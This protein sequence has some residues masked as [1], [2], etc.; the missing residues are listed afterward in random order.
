MLS[1]APSNPPISAVG[2]DATTQ[3]DT[4]DPLTLN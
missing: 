3:H 2:Y 4:D 1:Q